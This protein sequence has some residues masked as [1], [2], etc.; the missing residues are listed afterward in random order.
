[1]QKKD[2]WYF[3]IRSSIPRVWYLNNTECIEAINDVE[4]RLLEFSKIHTDCLKYI[5][6]RGKTKKTCVKWH[7]LMNL[8]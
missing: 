5:H 3:N 1:M 7:R 2:Q 4:P 8:S 6:G